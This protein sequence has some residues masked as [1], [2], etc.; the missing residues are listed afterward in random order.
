MW[1][2]K[3]LCNIIYLIHL[4]T[5]HWKAIALWYSWKIRQRNWHWIAVISYNAYSSVSHCAS[6]FPVVI[7]EFSDRYTF[8]QFHDDIAWVVHVSSPVIELGIESVSGNSIFDNSNRI[9]G[10]IC[11]F[12]PEVKHYNF[13]MLN[14]LKFYNKL[15]STK[16][17]TFN[18]K[19]NTSMYEVSFVSRYVSVDAG[20][21]NVTQWQ[22]STEWRI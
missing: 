12:P 4:Y 19:K 10:I 2:N 7:T 9:S 16:W 11:F 14:N 3:N 13:M 20:C 1:M 17:Y 21:E 5:F 15:M 6:A 8:F 22:G 18:P